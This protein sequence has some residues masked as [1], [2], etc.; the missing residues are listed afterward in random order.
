MNISRMIRN[1]KYKGY[2][3]GKKSEIVDYMSKK[4][5]YF[6]SDEWVIYEDLDNI[7]LI[8]DNNL[9]DRANKRI[10]KRIN[11]RSGN[12]RYLYSRK[13][14]CG[15]D[16]S[17]YNR[18]IFRRNKKDITWV[19]S[20]YL[21]NGKSSC[22]NFNLRESEI[23]SIFESIILK[24]DIRKKELINNL[25]S[26]Y[27]KIYANDFKSKLCNDRDIIY[28][29]RD[30]LIEL[31]I[32]GIISDIEFNVRNKVLNDEI[33]ELNKRIDNLLDDKKLDYSYIN[34][35]LNKKLNSNMVRDKIISL[36]LDK[37]LVYKVNDKIK[38]E[39]Y[40]NLK[41]KTPLKSKSYTFI[42]GDDVKCTRVYNVYYDVDVI[43][44][45]Q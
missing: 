19:C 45:N 37:I 31:N 34:K 42:R 41:N 27:T 18:R 43:F 10:N 5:K 11:K 35:I 6:S 32:N 29:K 1:P 12:K 3:C 30:K 13:I 44:K 38:L 28:L 26:Y 2:Y 33:D 17:I 8:V 24:L 20:N 40:L 21:K 4:V 36:I 16:N 39:I 25:I 14:Y 7:P 23:N 22:D 9:W 15:L